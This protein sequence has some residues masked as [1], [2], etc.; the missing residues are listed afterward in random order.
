MNE[1]P[2]SNDVSRGATVMTGFIFGALVGAGLA[3]LLAPATGEET[4]RRLGETAR[5]WRD[6]ARH[7]MGR[8]RE[9]LDE[10]KN[11]FKE[12]AQ[13]AVEAGREAFQ[14]GRQKQEPKGY[15]EPGSEVRPT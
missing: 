2:H 12:G 1:S 8:T 4:R 15:T 13:A 7:A 14:R 6:D 9:T 11:E 5:R 10:Y 3:L